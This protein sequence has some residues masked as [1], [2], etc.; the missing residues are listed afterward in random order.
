MNFKIIPTDYIIGLITKAKAEA[1]ITNAKF[2]NSGYGSPDLMK[3]L[4]MFIIALIG[5]VLVI[6]IIFLLKYLSNK[7]PLI[8]KLY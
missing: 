3:N 6:G 1:E 8:M 4:G 5:L 7:K 2:V